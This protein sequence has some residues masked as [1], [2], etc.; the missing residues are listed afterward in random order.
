M[1]WKDQGRQ[2]HVWFGHGTAP[3]K[4]RKAAPDPS[5]AGESIDERVLALAC[6]V[7]A[8][9]PA[10]L[11][12]RAEAQYQHGTLAHL[13]EAMTAWIKGIRPD[14]AR[15]ASRFLGRGI[16]DPVVRDLQ[17]A[18][19]GAAT[20]TGHEELRDAADKLASAIKVV[21]VDRWPRFV[22]DAAERARDP[23]TQAAIE[24]SMQPPHPAP[25]TIRPV[26]PI[27]TVIGIG[28]AGIAG[29]L[30]AAARAA[31]GT[32]LKHVL[33]EGRSPPVGRTGLPEPD[34]NS[35]PSAANRAEFESYTDALRRSMDR[36]A[37][38]DS[39]LSG[40]MDEMYRP[41]AKV[42]SGS[43]AAA[44]RSERATGQPIGGR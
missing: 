19:V 29:G 17:A 44:V 42:G 4:G 16:D 6:G 11:R 41:N 43:T 39:K 27:E 5:V 38:A 26:Y 22:A 32:I 40:I 33:P 25:D 21:S 1:S 12:R 35:A 23:A 7:I 14:Q 18:A 36:P 30:G 34:G 31:G 24:G 9:L 37:T 13:K 8:A 2:C 10:S 15:F 28:V 3:D 20:A